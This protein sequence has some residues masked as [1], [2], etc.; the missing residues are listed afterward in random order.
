MSEGKGST[1]ALRGAFTGGHKRTHFLPCVA[2]S[3]LETTVS[4]SESPDTR[5]KLP[6]MTIHVS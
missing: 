6:E 4:V 2:V 3:M 5:H 1:T